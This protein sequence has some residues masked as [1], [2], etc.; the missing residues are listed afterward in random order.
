M[1][2]CRLPQGASMQVLWVVVLVL[3]Q[4]WR[5]V[6]QLW[7]LQG[8]DC[9]REVWCWQL[10]RGHTMGSMMLP[11]VCSKASLQPITSIAINLCSETFLLTCR[12]LYKR[13]WTMLKTNRQ[14]CSQIQGDS[15]AGLAQYF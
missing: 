5:W 7:M 11:R 6:L 1:A 3:Q 14:V 13:G 15:Q 8:G 10:G 9:L 4:L 12:K 2:C